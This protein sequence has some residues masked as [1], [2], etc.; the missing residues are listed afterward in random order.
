MRR[1]ILGLTLGVATVTYVDYK[2][3]PKIFKNTYVRRFSCLFR[4]PHMDEVKDYIYAENKDDVTSYFAYGLSIPR[5]FKCQYR[6]YIIVDAVKEND[7]H[8][9]KYFQ[10]DLKLPDDSESIQWLITNASNE[11]LLFLFSNIDILRDNN[12]AYEELARQQRLAVICSLYPYCLL[13][14]KESIIS[15]LSNVPD[16]CDKHLASIIEKLHR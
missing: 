4:L 3:R 16:K 7:N 6:F 13:K 9:L 10:S 5:L 12:Y 14:Y 2:Y 1:S 15:N 8:I 11:N